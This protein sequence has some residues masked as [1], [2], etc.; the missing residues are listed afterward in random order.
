MNDPIS[1]NREGLAGLYLHVPFCHRKCPYCDF[2]SIEDASLI[3][4][5]VAALLSEIDMKAS[6]PYHFDTVYLGGG[7]PSMLSARQ[8]ESIIDHLATSFRFSAYPEIT[9][10][11]NP[12]TTSAEKLADYR[13]CGVNRLNIGVQSFDDALLT[14]LGRIHSAADAVTVLKQARNAGFENIGIDLIYGLPG[15]SM[16]R[17]IGDLTT[18]ISFEPQHLSCYMLTIEP[19]TPMERYRE[20]GEFQ[21]PEESHTI[22]LFDK[23]HSFLRKN[24]YIHYEISNYAASECYRSR[25]NM[26]Y[27]TFSPYAGFGPGAHSFNG[28][29][30]RCWN[31]RSVTDY[32]KFIALGRLPTADIEKLTMEQQITEAIYLG[33]RLTEGIRPA[34]VESRFGVDFEKLFGPGIRYLEEEGMAFYTEDRFHLTEKGIHFADGIASMLIDAIG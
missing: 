2:Y 33:L 24:G 25:H 12:G 6:L 32:L 9:L 18:A 28:R 5:Y 13:R 14:F 11:I 27:W 17:W 26:K 8:I 22:A 34:T 7:T 1:P 19:G 16:D 29:D 3:P 31:Y 15:Q 20:A 30:R 21:P 4:L 10:E 23:T